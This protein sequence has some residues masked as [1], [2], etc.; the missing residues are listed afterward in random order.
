[1]A[2]NQPQ[3]PITKADFQAWKHHPVT[4]CL[5][6]YLVDYQAALCREGWA[7]L[8]GGNLDPKFLTEIATRGKMS[9]EISELELESIEAFY[10]VEREE[11][12]ASS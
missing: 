12:N 6:K 7:A 10:G 3:L 1:M 8:K 4:K 11:E 5:H 2:A 9:E